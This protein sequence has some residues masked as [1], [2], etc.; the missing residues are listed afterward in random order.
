MEVLLFFVFAYFLGIPIIRFIIHWV[1][2]PLINFCVFL[3][4]VAIL[5]AQFLP[6][7]P[8]ETPAEQSP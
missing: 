1:V 6:E 3:I 2:F 8:A 4:I 5:T 7:T